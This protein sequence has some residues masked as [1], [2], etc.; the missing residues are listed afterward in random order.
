MLFDSFLLFFTSLAP[1][2]LLSIDA[3]ELARRQREEAFNVLEGYLYR[4]RDLLA[5]PPP[6]TEG[7]TP[8]ITSIFHDYSTEDERD[9]L[10]SGWERMGGTRR[11]TSW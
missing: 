7:T 8:T 11:Q 6:A 1:S 3:L 2:S 4:L 5:P 10:G 9:R